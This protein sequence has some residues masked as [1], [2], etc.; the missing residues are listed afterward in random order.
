MKNVI[1][2]KQKVTLTST[3]VRMS[4]NNF[5]ASSTQCSAHR[6]EKEPAPLKTS[7]EHASTME[8]NTAV[9]ISS[10]NYAVVCDVCLACD[11]TLLLN[12]MHLNPTRNLL[13]K[14]K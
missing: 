14:Q 12:I 8:A 2:L 10:N 3:N 9:V 6:C 13:R 1:L 4:A 5:S 7:P 11:R